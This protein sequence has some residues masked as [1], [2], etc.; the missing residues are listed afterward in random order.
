MFLNQQTLTWKMAIKKK[1]KCPL[2][3]TRTTRP[4]GGLPNFKKKII[5][6]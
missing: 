3:G 6:K 4:G 2:S 1:S 5:N